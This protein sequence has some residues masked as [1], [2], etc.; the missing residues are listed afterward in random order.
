MKNK[1]ILIEAPDHHDQIRRSVSELMEELSWRS[2]VKSGA[3]VFLKINAA[4]TYPE[5]MQASNTDKRIIAAVCAILQE[6]T[7]DITIVESD[8][9]LETFDAVFTK[10]EMYDFARKIGVKVLNL[11]ASKQV[12]ALHPLLEN[13]GLPECLL[14]EDRVFIT[15]PVI[16]THVVTTFT[17]ALKNQWGCIP[18]YDRFLLHKNIHE[19]I[20]I[21][22]TLMRPDLAIMDGIWCME[23]RGPTSGKPRRFGVLLGSTAPASLDATS[24]RLIGADPSTCKHLVNSSGPGLGSIAEAD[25]EIVGDFS[26]FKTHFEPAQMG[27]PLRLQ[28]YLSRYPFFVHHI[29]TNKALFRAGKY[30]VN[31]LRRVGLSK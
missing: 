8:G 21:I 19:L 6:R 29:N 4:G 16:K 18:R 5:T 27:W 26:R 30:S 9:M 2:I 14:S 7:D 15:L 12:R 10:F 11:S 17:G 24:M 22:N 13:F 1:V 31:L 3:R 20:P 23:G 25:I 28:N